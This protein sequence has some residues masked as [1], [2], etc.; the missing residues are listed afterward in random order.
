MAAPVEKERSVMDRV[1]AGELTLADITPVRVGVAETSK[2]SA[3][4]ESRGILPAFSAEKQS[5]R[6]AIQTPERTGFGV[7]TSGTGNRGLETEMEAPRKERTPAPRREGKRAAREEEAAP[8]EE[9]PAQEEKPAKRNLAAERPVKSDDFD[10][11]FEE[12]SAPAQKSAGKRKK[13]GDE[14]FL[15]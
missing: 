15:F 11:A 6:E 7:E 1:R 4:A 10:V 14:D 9:A 3:M 2:V 12:A 5:Y 13:S 8:K